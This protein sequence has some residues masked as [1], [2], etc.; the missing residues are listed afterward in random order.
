MG[1]MGITRGATT[2]TH[3]HEALWLDTEA[4][5]HAWMRD[6][7]AKQPEAIQKE[8]AMFTVRPRVSA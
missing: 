8:A 6:W 4:E 2:W 7:L 5:A 1:S 3:H